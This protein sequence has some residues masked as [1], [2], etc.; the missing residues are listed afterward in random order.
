MALIIVEFSAYFYVVGMKLFNHLKYSWTL[1]KEVTFLKV[2]I[3]NKLI[4]VS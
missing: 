2:N 4:K 3:C 1:D